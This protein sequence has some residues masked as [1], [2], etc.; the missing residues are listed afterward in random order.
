MGEISLNI[1]LMVDGGADVSEKIKQSL[2]LITVPLYLHFE[3]KQYTSGVDM[4]LHQFYEKIKMKNSLPRTSAPSPSDFYEA[5]KK[6][7]PDKP[8][9]MLSMTKGLSST[10]ENAVSGR[11][12]LL[13]E[14]PARVIEVIDTKTASCGVGLLLH[15]T[16]TMINENISYKDIVERIKERVNDTATLF[17]LKSLDN[18]I[19][20]G[21]LDKVKGTIAKTLNIK[22]LMRENNGEIEVTEKVRGDKKSLRRFIGQIGEY[23]KNIE[24]KVLTITHCNDEKRA[25]SVIQDIK[26]MYPFK[27]IFL[28]ETGP[29]ISTYAGEG[30]LVMSFFKN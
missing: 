5:F 6:V 22:L 4:N 28:S 25:H 9:I 17:V 18:L 1:Q 2:D 11:N 23:T 21:R 27:D 16:N 20:G 12:M 10:Y 7:D 15:E 13:D 14:E 24:D 26:K 19:L 8:I 29:L 3:D 30:A